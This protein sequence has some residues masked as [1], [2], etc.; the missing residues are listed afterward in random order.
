MKIKTDL[1]LLSGQ[2]VSRR[3]KRL[4]RIKIAK[5]EKDIIFEI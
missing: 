2:S 1:M 3:Q 4:L 5:R